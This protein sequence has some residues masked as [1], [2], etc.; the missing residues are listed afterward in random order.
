MYS[1]G[2]NFHLPC[3][4]TKLN[5]IQRSLPVLYKSEK[6]KKSNMDAIILQRPWHDHGETLTLV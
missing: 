4:K 3:T 2:Y 5:I 6:I 1:S